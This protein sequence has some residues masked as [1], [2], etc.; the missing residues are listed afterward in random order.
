MLMEIDRLMII[1]DIKRINNEPDLEKRRNLCDKFIDQIRLKVGDAERVEYAGGAIYDTYINYDSNCGLTIVSDR[2]DIDELAGYLAKS[3]D[4]TNNFD[5]DHPVET[6]DDLEF[7]D[8]L[9]ILGNHPQRSSDLEDLIDEQFYV[10]PGFP[11]VE[12]AYRVS[13]VAND[14]PVDEK[15]VMD[16][17]KE[18]YEKQCNELNNN[19]E[20]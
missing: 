13:Y 2:M 19:L 18:E 15:K 7:S 8:I 10:K 14:V 5:L 11:E 6:I 12:V 17:L 20:A 4:I 3:S 1:M 16:D 9:Q